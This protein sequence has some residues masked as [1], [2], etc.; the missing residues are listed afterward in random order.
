MPATTGT[1]HYSKFTL[2]KSREDPYH[3]LP[4]W[5][6]SSFAIYIWAAAIIIQIIRVIITIAAHINNYKRN[7]YA[8]SSR[9]YKTSKHPMYWEL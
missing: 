2:V 9:Y 5:N 6:I 3:D 7:S 4:I 1:K 8:S